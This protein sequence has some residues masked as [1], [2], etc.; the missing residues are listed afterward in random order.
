M[1]LLYALCALL[2]Y[3]QMTGQVPASLFALFAVLTVVLHIVRRP[4]RRIKSNRPLLIRLVRNA[5]ASYLRDQRWERDHQS[6][7][8]W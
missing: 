1:T 2:A 8:A 5:R 6:G 7:T 4:R 3:G